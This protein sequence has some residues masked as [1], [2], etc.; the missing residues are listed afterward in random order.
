M[1]SVIF[2]TGPAGETYWAL[3]WGIV[4]VVMFYKWSWTHN[5]FLF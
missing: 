3:G 5:T 4:D 2:E 1:V